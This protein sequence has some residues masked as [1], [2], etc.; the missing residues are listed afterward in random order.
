MIILTLLG[1]DEM[2]ICANV[3]LFI[4]ELPA[5]EDVDC[6]KSKG[7]LMLKCRKVQ[8]ANHNKPQ[9]AK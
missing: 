1:L 6:P 2:P 3:R 4:E 5:L 7:Y 9:K 8:K